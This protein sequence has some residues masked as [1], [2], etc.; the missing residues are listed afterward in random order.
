MTRSLTAAMSAKRRR[1]LTPSAASSQPHRAP[2]WMRRPR[3]V[4]GDTNGTGSGTSVTGSTGSFDGADQETVA[5]GEGDGVKSSVGMSRTHDC[6]ME[7]AAAI[8]PV[9]RTQ[10]SDS[11]GASSRSTRLASC[12]KSSDGRKPSGCETS[13][14]SLE[15]SSSEG[16]SAVGLA[17]G[18]NV[19]H[20]LHCSGA[21]ECL[22]ASHDAP[23]DYSHCLCPKTSSSNTHIDRPWV[24]TQQLYLQMCV[25]TADV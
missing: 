20:R 19:H 1:A 7:L 10:T 3:T 12:T 4:S 25:H 8:T 18:D 5:G 14:R 24:S 21:G 15:L 13:S 22:C 9:Q 23:A 17:S 16:H 6:G 11:H 2:Y